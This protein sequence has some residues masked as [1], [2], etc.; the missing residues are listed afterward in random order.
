MLLLLVSYSF[1]LQP[2]YQPPKEE[3]Y[4]D[5]NVG[6][7]G[8]L[9]GYILARK[10]G[11]YAIVDETGLEIPVQKENIDLLISDGFELREE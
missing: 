3:V 10:D 5:S 1:I 8:T 4:T 6:T 9:S 7:S 2:Q 11:T